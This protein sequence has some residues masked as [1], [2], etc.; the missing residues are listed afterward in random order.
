MELS[1]EDPTL[2]NRR[3]ELRAVIGGATY[4]SSVNKLPMLSLPTA[5]STLMPVATTKG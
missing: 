3:D 2:L 1:A 4:Y 5:L